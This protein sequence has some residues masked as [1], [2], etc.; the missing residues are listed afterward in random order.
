ME[1]LKIA[2]WFTYN[3]YYKGSLD[4]L[5]IWNKGSIQFVSENKIDLYDSKGVFYKTEVNKKYI[6]K[7]SDVRI[8]NLI[9]ERSEIIQIDYDFYLIPTSCRLALKDNRIKTKH[10]L[11]DYGLKGFDLDYKNAIQEVNHYTLKRTKYKT[12]RPLEICFNDIY[13]FNT[14]SFMNFNYKKYIENYNIALKKYPSHKDSL[15]YLKEINL[16]IICDFYEIDIDVLKK[17]NF[18]RFRY[19]IKALNNKITNKKINN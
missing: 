11:I 1:D 7:N 5:E 8:D 10:M 6:D 12:Q 4:N 14:K 16:N 15:Y 9:N 17:Q 3:D 13:R 19:A 2:S 18:N